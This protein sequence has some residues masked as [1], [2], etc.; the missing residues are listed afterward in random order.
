MIIVRKMIDWRISIPTPHLR[1][2]SLRRQFTLH[3][4]TLTAMLPRRER[5]E[6]GLKLSIF[7]GTLTDTYN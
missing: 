5:L 1:I 2:F 4:H 6:R 3:T 7:S